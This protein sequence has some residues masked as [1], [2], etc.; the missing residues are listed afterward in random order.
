MRFSSISFRLLGLLILAIVGTALVT[1]SFVWFE[2][3]TLVRDRKRQ[4]KVSVEIAYNILQKQYELSQ[5][6]AIS[7]DAAK[8]TAKAL[9]KALRYD[10]KEYFWINDTSSPAHM[11]MH[12]TVPDLDGKTLDAPKFNC[13]TYSQ[14]GVNGP[15]TIWTIRTC[16]QPL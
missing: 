10:E 14:E 5:S 2:Y 16:L 13:A 7:E 11:I 9:I 8:Q 12:P 15:D 1:G 4:L 6:G 3:D